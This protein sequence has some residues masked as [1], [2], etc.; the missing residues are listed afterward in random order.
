MGRIQFSGGNA[1]R[2][3]STTY[4][5]RVAEVDD[6]TLVVRLGLQHPDTI[7]QLLGDCLR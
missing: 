1:G 7:V 3:R 4:A 6:A 5:T 2:E